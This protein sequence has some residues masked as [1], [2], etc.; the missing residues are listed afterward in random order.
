MDDIQVDMFEVQLGAALLLQFRNDGN[1]TVTVLADAGIKV[2]PSYA[3]S[4]V[5]N[6]L[7]AAVQSFTGRAKAVHV[8]LMIGTHYDEDHLRGLTAVVQDPTRAVEEAW[9]PPVAVD[10]EQETLA[11]L[12]ATTRG[13]EV[14]GR[15]IA[16]HRRL[17]AVAMSLR[18]QPDDIVP[19]LRADLPEWLWSTIV[20]L[21]AHGSRADVLEEF[22]QRTREDL[23]AIDISASPEEDRQRGSYDRDLRELDALARDADRWVKRLDSGEYYDAV[24][25]PER[26]GAALEIA[27]GRL[28]SIDLAS[29]KAWI[30][31]GAPGQ[32]DP[33]QTILRLAIIQKSAAKNAITA[34]HLDKLVKA[35]KQRGVRMYCKTINPGKPKYFGWDTTTARFVENCTESCEPKLTLLAPSRDLVQKHHALLPR[36][37]NAALLLF[38]GVE[39]DVRSITPSNQLSYVC[40][41]A[42]QNQR[43][44]ICGDS[45]F[46]DFRKAGARAFYADLLAELDR[47]Q[48]LQIAHHAGN[49]QFFY[50][51]LLNSNYPGQ[52]DKS[53]HLVS[54][55]T[56]DCRRPS[57]AYAQFAA[58]LVGKR[59]DFR[60]LFTAKPDHAKVQKF[61]P[62]IHP[63]EPTG[64]NAQNCGDVRLAYS[65]NGWRVLEHRVR[66]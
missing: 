64:T 21:S 59:H 47:L 2:Q 27:S 1:E 36:Y 20:L 60:I 14:L 3:E 24:T 61:L 35:L 38:A 4:H 31:S 10:G 22:V 11:E 51:C 50:H 7:P 66:A 37:L 40:V 25:D 44:L 8:N 48:V 65:A 63:L 12:L 62:Q 49:N 57:K 58:A 42:H 53:L 30:N 9:L 29:L 52:Q 6:K 5:N 15:Y 19:Q 46:T 45:G 23:H 41:V 16:A 28:D 39:I 26:W 13:E 43:I 17:A 55:A 54:H 32:L 18:N 56:H 34:I 33:A